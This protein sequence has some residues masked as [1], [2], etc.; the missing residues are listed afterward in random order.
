MIDR[1][2]LDLGIEPLLA[3]AIGKGQTGYENAIE[4]CAHF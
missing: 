2:D 4:K 3:A 1:S